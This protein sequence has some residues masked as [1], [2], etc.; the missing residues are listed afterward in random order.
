MGFQTTELERHESG[1]TPLFIMLP[2]AEQKT[3]LLATIEAFN[4]S[5]QYVIEQSLSKDIINK[6]AI[7]PV[8]Y[9]VLR[10]KYGLSAQM[11]VRAIS[12]GVEMSKRHV[13]TFCPHWRL[14]KNR[15]NIELLSAEHPVLGPYA[16]MQFDDLM[17]SFPSI[18]TVSI[19]C[20]DGRQKIPI[21]YCIYKKRT[22][23]LPFTLL[24]CNR[25]S[26]KRS[27]V[28]FVHLPVSKR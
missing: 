20:L 19:L 2:S 23:K 7:Q 25:G 4:Q 15:K 21:R 9:S 18:F 22:D 14:R 1:L 27:T 8:V 12:T 6:I 24:N 13:Q 28:F 11:A 17:I 26:D 10:E 3:K 5:C 16:S